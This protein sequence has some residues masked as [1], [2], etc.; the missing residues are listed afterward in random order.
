MLFT[1]GLR[2][3]DITFLVVSHHADYQMS[4]S[5]PAFYPINITH[6]ENNYFLRVDYSSNFQES[7]SVVWARVLR[8]TMEKARKSAGCRINGPVSSHDDI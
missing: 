4:V 2:E 5:N 3:I 8:V 1:T 7:K 6:R